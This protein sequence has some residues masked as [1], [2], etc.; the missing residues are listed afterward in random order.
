MVR[1]YICTSIA[2]IYPNTMMSSWW[3]NISGTYSYGMQST[4][5]GFSF[6]FLFHTKLKGD[7][8]QTWSH[9]SSGQILHNWDD[10]FSSKTKCLWNMVMNGKLVTFRNCSLDWEFETVQPC[11]CNF[12]KF[13]LQL[14]LFRDC[15]PKNVQ[16]TWGILNECMLLR[17]MNGWEVWT[18]MSGTWPWRWGW[19]S[20]FAESLGPAQLFALQL[21][22]SAAL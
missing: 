6:N 9:W 12:T 18:C 16:F 22:K 2:V 21:V 5:M 10:A 20:R 17:I 1:H 3:Y 15:F 4:M 13:R 7:H 8:Q 19:D 11:A 14:I